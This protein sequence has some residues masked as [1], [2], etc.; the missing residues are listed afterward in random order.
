MKRIISL[1]II[2]GLLTL[3]QI[4]PASAQSANNLSLTASTPNVASGQ[5][6]LVTLQGN[7]STPSQGFSL[8][9]RY[10]PACLQLLKHTPTGLLPADAF[11]VETKA[12]G[13]LDVAYTLLG[14]AK[15]FSGSGALLEIEFKTLKTCQTNLSLES[16]KLMASNEQGLA[17]YV[18]TELGAPLSVSIIS[19]GVVL[20][21]Q[22]PAEQTSQPATA[23]PTNEAQP[24][25]V[26]GI[27]T[28]ND[29]GIDWF[30]PATLGTLTLIAVFAFFGLILRLKTPHRTAPAS[31]KTRPAP[32]SAP[33][34]QIEQGAQPARVA[35]STSPFN[36]GRDAGNQLNLPNPLVSRTHAQLFRIGADW[37]I[38]DNH[39]SNGTFVN[40]QR[41]QQPCP[42]RP[43]DYIRLGR[44][45]VMRFG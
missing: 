43:G 19:T 42:L 11:P 15:T 35:L 36:I 39:S 32:V 1:L 3:F 27:Q 4:R 34:I 22:P 18:D 2:I 24:T 33:V 23:Q 8:Q 45:V 16:A 31:Y 10:D 7:V 21:P 12:D 26:T 37:Y 40:G 5:N 25:P 14:G 29:T 28:G 41:I 38:S 44:Q 9:L 6:L 17:Y 20:T 30:L 13:L